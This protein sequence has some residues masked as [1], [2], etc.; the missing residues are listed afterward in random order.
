MRIVKPWGEEIIIVNDPVANYCGKLLRINKGFQTSIHKHNIKD[1][2]LYINK[3][4]LYMMLNMYSEN[5][6]CSE[7]IAGDA[8]RIV[9]DVFHRMIALED[10]EIVEFSTYHNDKDTERREIGGQISA[11]LLN[12]LEALVGASTRK[13]LMEVD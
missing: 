7:M 3:G 11:G 6:K 13:S 8:A 12:K 2:T 5:S 4:R 9:P 10:V 1:E